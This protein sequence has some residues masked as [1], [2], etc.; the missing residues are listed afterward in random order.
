MSEHERTFYSEYRTMIPRNP[1]GGW[2]RLGGTSPVTY[3]EAC[4]EVLAEMEDD[5]TS[6]SLHRYIYRIVDTKGLVVMTG[7][8][9]TESVNPVT[10]R[11]WEA[12][13]MTESEILRRW[14]I[15]DSLI[16]EHDNAVAEEKEAEDQVRK[17]VENENWYAV[18]FFN[19]RRAI[20]SKTASDLKVYLTAGD[21]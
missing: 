7:S 16:E 19:Q 11:D 3:Q 21:E 2:F 1:S 13:G 18:K 9:L 10:G 12:E 5:K 15:V 4:A 20:R 17:A 6:S 8:E 14:K